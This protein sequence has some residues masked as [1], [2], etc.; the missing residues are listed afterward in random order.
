VDIGTYHQPARRHHHDRID[1]IKGSGAKEDFG[2]SNVMKITLS[3]DHCAVD[4]AVIEN[5]LHHR[6]FKSTPG[7][8]DDAGMKC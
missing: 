6:P 7:T 5:F 2:V 4:S 8:S 1:C 3:C